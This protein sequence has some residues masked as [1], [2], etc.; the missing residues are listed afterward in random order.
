MRFLAGVQRAVPAGKV[1]H[2]II[3]SDAIH[4]HLAWLADLPRWVF[5]FTSKSASWINA[6]E[7]SFSIISRRSIRR[8]VFKSVADLQD[9]IARYIRARNKAPK[10]FVCTKPVDIIFA[11]LD[12]LPAPSE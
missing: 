7:G 3:D 5:H 12:R 8:G 1:I 11:K 9:A 6:V 2:A 4:T 10:P